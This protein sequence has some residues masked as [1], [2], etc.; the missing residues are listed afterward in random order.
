MTSR[1]KRLRRIAIWRAYQRR[2]DR[3]VGDQ[4]KRRIGHPMRT[5]QGYFRAEGFDTRHRWW[6]E[7][8]HGA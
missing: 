2:N 1:R 5:N 7:L 4:W 6:R 8:R 3:L